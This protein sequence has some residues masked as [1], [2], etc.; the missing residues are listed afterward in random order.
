[1]RRIGQKTERSTLSITLRRDMRPKF[2]SRIAVPGALGRG[3]TAG[4]GEGISTKRSL[5]GS[6]GARAMHQWGKRVHNTGGGSKRNG[7]WT[8]NEKELI[9]SR[10]TRIQVRCGN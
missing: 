4:A 7:L 5:L 6:P 9:E 3:F 10:K 8:G 1:M 2:G